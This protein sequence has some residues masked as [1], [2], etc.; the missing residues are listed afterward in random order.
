[1]FR[2]DLRKDLL[3]NAVQIEKDF[4]LQFRDVGNG[5]QIFYIGEGES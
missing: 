5:I 3:A 4:R 2:S 1:S